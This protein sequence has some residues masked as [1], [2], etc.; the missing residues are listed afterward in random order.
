MALIKRSQEAGMT[1]KKKIAKKQAKKD[2]KQTVTLKADPAT[3]KFLQRVCDLSEQSI[4]T[5]VAV[6][7]AI[8]IAKGEGHE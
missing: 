4:D 3:Q 7:L 5:V 8:Q 6:I 1:V 2:D